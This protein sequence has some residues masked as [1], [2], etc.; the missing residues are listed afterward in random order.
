MLVYF[1][2]GQLPWQGMRTTNTEERNVLILEQKRQIASASLCK[3][4]PSEFVE[5][6]DLLGSS[7][8]ARVPP[9]SK[10]R[11]LFTAL[12][13]ALG[14]EYDQVFDWTELKF[15]ARFETD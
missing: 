9:Y 11:H 10:L 4:L 1:L 2:N 8:R 7:T 15:Q 3:G 6:F 12:F 13:R 5:Y 14:H